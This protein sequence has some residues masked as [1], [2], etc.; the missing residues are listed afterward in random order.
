MYNYDVIINVN[1]VVFSGENYSY[2]HLTAVHEYIYPVMD[3]QKPVA[4]RRDSTSSL[5]KRSLEI[6]PTQPALLAKTKHKNNKNLQTQCRH[7]HER[8]SEDDNPKGSCEYAPDCIKDGIEKISCL[9]CAQCMLYHCMADAEGDFAAH[10]CECGPID[11]NCSKR[12]LGIAL[13]SLFVP[14]LWCYPA[15]KSCHW[16]GTK[17]GICGGRHSIN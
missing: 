10:P 16:C 7:C 11:E 6:M 15:L 2:V 8:F 9:S 14:C 12:W 4:G 13:L 5:K 3:D 1:F 17:I